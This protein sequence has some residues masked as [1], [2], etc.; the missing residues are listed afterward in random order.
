VDTGSCRSSA[1]KGKRGQ[2][3]RQSN[4]SQKQKNIPFSQ[5]NPLLWVKPMPG[6]GELCC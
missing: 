4:G 1:A 5:K 3:K 2:H 6:G